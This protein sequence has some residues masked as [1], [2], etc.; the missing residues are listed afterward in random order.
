[1]VRRGQCRMAYSP[2]CSLRQSTSG[3]SV[4]QDHGEPSWVAA[5]FVPEIFPIGAKYL[6]KKN[7]SAHVPKTSS[8]PP[9]LTVPMRRGPGCLH[10]L[11]SQKFSLSL[12]FYIQNI[13]GT[14]D[15]HL[16]STDAWKTKCPGLTRRGRKEDMF[17]A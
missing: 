2:P 6:F 1:M 8:S 10:V 3:S 16:I 5:A 13:S 4:T 15:L 17:Q 9:P 7:C 11:L 14:L 12:I